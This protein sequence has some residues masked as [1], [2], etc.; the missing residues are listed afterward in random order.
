MDFFPQDEIN[1]NSNDC[2]ISLKLEFFSLKNSS[3]EVVRQLR[4]FLFSIFIF[5]LSKSQF[6]FYE[7]E[8]LN[9]EFMRMSELRLDS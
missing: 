9:F 6:Y 3:I 2:L 5:S 1:T 4:P 8:L 7:I